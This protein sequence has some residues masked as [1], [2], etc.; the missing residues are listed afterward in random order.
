MKGEYDR[1]LLRK[2]SDARKARRR[3]YWYRNR[4]GTVGANTYKYWSIPSLL[5]FLVIVTTVVL[6]VL[7]CESWI[8]AIYE[9]MLV[10]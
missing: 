9:S 5:V 8:V 3:N 1:V 4:R 7:K 6:I 10:Y 2:A